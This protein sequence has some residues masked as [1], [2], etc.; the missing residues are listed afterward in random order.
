MVI[1]TTLSKIIVNFINKSHYKCNKSIVIKDSGYI[2][3]EF[4][5]L[6]SKIITFKI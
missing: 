2:I 4:E 5:A 6:V 1:F 3:I